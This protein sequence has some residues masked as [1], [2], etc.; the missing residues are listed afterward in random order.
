MPS[1]LFYSGPS[2]DELHAQYARQGKLDEQAPIKVSQTIHVEAP[3]ERVWELLIN[4]SEWPAIDPS[5]RDVRLQDAVGVDS[6]F[7]F[8]LNGFP[9]NAK[10]AVIEPYRHLHWTGVS[11]WFKAVDLHSLEPAG[12]GGTRLY[13]AESFAGFLAPLFMNNERLNAQHEKWLMAFKRTAEG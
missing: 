7:S 11:L 6:R 2:F 3:V 13:I 1:R 10:I 5:I 12:D 8:K 9:I 4:L